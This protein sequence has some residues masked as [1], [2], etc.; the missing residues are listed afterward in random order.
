MHVGAD[1]LLETPTINRALALASRAVAAEFVPLR[2]FAQRRTCWSEERFE[3]CPC[4]T[5]VKPPRHP[6]NLAP[7]L[8][9]SH[10]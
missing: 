9:A 2:Q 6:I 7:A 3:V 4:G 10:A 8:V 1:A 5:L